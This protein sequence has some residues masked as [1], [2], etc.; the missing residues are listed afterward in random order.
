MRKRFKNVTLYER[1]YEALKE[2]ILNNEYLPGDIVTIELIARE[3]GVS[4]TPVREAVAR[5][6]A[7]GLVRQA[8]NKGVRIAPIT[9]KDVHNTY[10]VRKLLEPYVAGVAAK[11]IAQDPEYKRGLLQVKKMA[12]K[13]ASILANNSAVPSYETYLQV[14]LKLERLML[15]AVENSLL[16]RLIAFVSSHS[17][18]I[19]SFAEAS[20]NSSAIEMMRTIN[21]EHLHIIEAILNADTGEAW[22]A[23]KRHL[24]NAERRTINQLEGRSYST[25]ERFLEEEV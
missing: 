4:A 3:L 20:S 9:S 2:A 11:K 16:Q 21:E 7:E 14:D 10:E 1:V 5:L 17:R 25:L 18:R 13:V 22:K 15:E 12:E 6:S 8:P 24:D 23:V 19:R